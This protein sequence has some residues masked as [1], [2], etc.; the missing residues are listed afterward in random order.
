MRWLTIAIGLTAAAGIIIGAAFAQ[1]QSRA[2][3]AEQPV[4]PCPESTE[5]GCNGV[6]RCVWLP[7]Y[8]GTSGIDIP[9]DCHPDPHPCLNFTEFDCAGLSKYVWLGSYRVASGGEVPGYCRPAA[10]SLTARRGSQ[11]PHPENPGPSLIVTYSHC[12]AHGFDLR[13]GMKQQDV[14]T[15]SGCWPLPTL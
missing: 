9:D 7:G 8:R 3:P 4:D 12:I 5:I 11:I 15:A 13:F 10:K 6:A 14:A 1:E 2:P